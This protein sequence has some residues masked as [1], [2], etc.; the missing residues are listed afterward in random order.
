MNQTVEEYVTAWQEL[1]LSGARLIME[2][3]IEHGEETIQ[4]EM[5]RQGL[6]ERVN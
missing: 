3:I 2:A 6:I 1:R 4:A 5:I